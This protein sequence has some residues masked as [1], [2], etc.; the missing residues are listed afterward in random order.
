MCRFGWPRGPSALSSLAP[1]HTLACSLV[2]PFA[3]LKS[4]PAGFCVTRPLASHLPH[5]LAPTDLALF[6]LSAWSRVVTRRRGTRDAQCVCLAESGR[7]WVPANRSQRRRGRVK[8]ATD[9]GTEASPIRLP[10]N[11]PKKTSIK[12]PLLTQAPLACRLQ[13]TTPA[14][15]GQTQLEARETSREPVFRDVN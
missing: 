1:I 12:P 2:S 9:R 13:N 11:H 8:S 14:C 3:T 10:S 5:T 15:L 6:G 4:D 7:M